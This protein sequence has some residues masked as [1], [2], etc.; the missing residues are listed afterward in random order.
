MQTND[1]QKLHDFVADTLIK[2]GD[3]N[4]LSDTDL[5]FTNGR[6][7]SFSTMNLVM[8]LEESFGIDFSDFEFDVGVLDS[9]DLIESFI[10][11]RR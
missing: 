10:D 5:L 9:I 2:H 3:R 4:P 11:A 7:D 8:F 6:L 1:K